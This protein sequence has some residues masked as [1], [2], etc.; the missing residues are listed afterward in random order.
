MAAGEKGDAEIDREG[1][2]EALAE[3]TLDEAYL[4][5]AS[6]AQGMRLASRRAASDAGG[7]LDDAYGEA[8]RRARAVA[9]A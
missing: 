6:G 7:R 4:A 2:A 1:C 8:R 9:E 5:P 3:G